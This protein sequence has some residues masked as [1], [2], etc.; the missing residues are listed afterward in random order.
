MGLFV[1]HQRLLIISLLKNVE[2]EGPKVNFSKITLLI[3]VVFWGT[4]SPAISDVK[5]TNGSIN[6]DVNFDGATEMVLN[7]VG[8]G[9]GTSTV[10]SNLNVSGNAIISH[11]L[12][13]GS[14]SGSSNLSVSGTV[15]FGFSNVS[16][17]TS[18][19]DN[20]N[21]VILADTTSGNLNI[22]LPSASDVNGRVYDIKKIN[23]SHDLIITGGLIDNYSDLTFSSNSLGYASV[24]ANSSQWHILSMSGNESSISAD[25]LVAWYPLNEDSGTVAYDQSVNS[26]NGNL[27]NGFTFSA[28]QAAGVFSDG[29]DF[30]GTDDR[31]DGG[32][33]ASLDLRDSITIALWVNSDL[34]GG[35]MRPFITK[36]YSYTLRTTGFNRIDFLL[37]IGGS[38]LYAKSQD[39]A[40]IFGTWQHIVGTYDRSDGGN[41]MKLYIDGSEVTYS[42]QDDTAGAQMDSTVGQNLLIGMRRDS[43]YFDGKL[44]DVRI[45]SRAF[46]A[47]EVRALYEIGK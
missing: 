20:L 1:N 14:T 8:L 42:Q 29:L 37:K 3:L 28:N 27:I 34:I 47:S 18:L 4:I 39:N 22:S 24:I 11:S 36:D 30:D 16:S 10:S 2:D 46:S 7:E 35:L 31:I 15:G 9:I 21:S 38:T 6:F 13:V 19:S 45:Y 40:L 25:N 43:Y 5:S 32:D 26:N 33:D 12:V 17:D 41:V 44:D 23:G